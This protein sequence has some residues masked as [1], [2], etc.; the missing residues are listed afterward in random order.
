MES[1]ELIKSRSK[2]RLLALT[3]AGICII[4][5]FLLFLFAPDAPNEGSVN[6][7]YLNKK[8][9]LANV[10]P[11]VFF[12]LFGAAITIYSIVT[13]LKMK[14][15][16]KK[17]NEEDTVEGTNTIEYTY[18]LNNKKDSQENINLRG[19][20]LQ[21]F[22]TF[23]KISHEIELSENISPDIKLKYETAMENVKDY[24][25]RSLWDSSWGSYDEFKKWLNKGCPEPVTDNIS[26]AAEFFL[27]KQ[28]KQK[29]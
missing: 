23:S 9:A 2:E 24:I 16:S 7:E 8:F 4:L 29:Q 11:G 6:I 17:N 13:Q 26:D 28:L 22:R 15:V 14:N 21:D 19:E 1:L 18:L 20:F 27:G 3:V 12:A 10:G 25:M 5:G